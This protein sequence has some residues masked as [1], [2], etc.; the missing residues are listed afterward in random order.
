MSEP[1]RIGVDG[2]MF[3]DQ[4]RGHS[5]YAYRICREL[6][7]HLPGARFFLYAP[8]D[9]DLSSFKGDWIRRT[10]RAATSLSPVA[11]LKT[12]GSLLA[13]KD[14]LHVFWSPYVFLPLLPSQVR[15]MIT[16]HDLIG[17]LSPESFSP[18]HSLAF[19]FFLNSD[20][21]RASSIIA[22]SHGTQ[23]RVLARYGRESVVIPPSLSPDF[24][25]PTPAVFAK[26]LDQHGISGRYL[27]NV[28]A[29]EP[30]KNIELLIRTFLRMK[31]EG[32]LPS[33]KLLLTG[34]KERGCDGIE[35]LIKSCGQGLVRDLG[36]VPEADLPS[37]YAGADAL[38]FP[39]IYEGFGMP[40]LEARNCGTTVVTTDLP[41]LREAGGDGCIYIEP[42]EEGIRQ[43]II[44]ALEAVGPLRDSSYSGSWHESAG[45]LAGEILRLVHTHR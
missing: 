35:R 21:K 44:A 25:R 19:R 8:H 24:R 39:S 29:W 22:N 26:V 6:G 13:R 12:A 28:A 36:Y 23:N 4:P 2:S 20:M 7:D 1:L 11:W 45:I 14:G 42:T 5:L 3:S 43:G 32:L 30:R 37:L 16:F 40:V 38:V 34:R 27:L 10:N 9:S 18:L 31:R 41:E 17:D 33:H 15:A